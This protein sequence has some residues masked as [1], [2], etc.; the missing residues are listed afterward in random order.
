MPVTTV[1]IMG[2]AGRDFHNFNVVYRDH[3][4]YRVIAFTA[5]QIP[6][7]AGRVYPAVLAGHLYPDGIAIYPEGELE[8]LI[9]TYGIDQVV[10]SYSDLSYEEV[11][12][13][14]SRVIAAGADF[15]LLSARRTMLQAAKP[16]VSLCAVRTGAGKSPATR[17]V[18]ALLREEGLRV[19]IIRHPMPYG[20]L[21][22]QAVQRFACLDDLRAANC[23]IEEMEEYEP[24]IV[25][26]DV[27]YAGVDYER[28]LHE[29]AREADVLLWDGGNNDTPFV[30]PDLEIVLLD[31][32]RAGHE[33]TYFPGEVNLLRAD[34]LVITKMDT[35][36]PEQIHVVRANIRQL[37]PKAAVLETVMPVT[38]VPPHLINGKRVLVI[39][40]GP[41]LTHGGMSSGAGV[42]AAKQQ[43]ARELVDPR[44][45]AVGT[46][47]QTFIQYPHIGSVLPAMGYGATQ[48]RELEETVNRIPCDVVLIATPVD[49]GRIITITHPTCRVTYRLEEQGALGFRDVMQ[50]IILQAK[51]DESFSR[52][53]PLT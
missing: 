6:N 21:A 31:P 29:A 36:S 46:I 11:M 51:R 35:A 8:S 53:L 1:L 33:Q 48:V 30:V 12:H 26:G 3:P 4:E 19:V 44:A 34:V 39:E 20:D 7:I 15:R 2:A 9:R 50:G 16:V 32:H 42:L 49:L 18:A 13:R 25:Q 45:Y 41:T 23:T 27:V 22:K 14:A 24:H 40:D 28:I 37:N 10:F 47:Q 38:V 52:R 43:G 17:R 5:A